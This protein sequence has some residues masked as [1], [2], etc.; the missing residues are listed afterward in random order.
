MLKTKYDMLTRNGNEH[1]VVV[2]L[3][4]YEALLEQMEDEA[5]FRALEAAKKRNA[6]KP[7][8]PHS[9]I[10]EE[11]GLSRLLRKAKRSDH[12]QPGIPFA[13]VKREL[14]ESRKGRTR[15]SV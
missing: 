7:R 15:K 3:K 1:F 9:Q 11:F 8:I 5:D 13:K 2:P 14:A 12:G 6:G 10:L 4:D